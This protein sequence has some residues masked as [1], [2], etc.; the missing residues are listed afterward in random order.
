[1]F[2]KFPGRERSADWMDARLNGQPFASERWFVEASGR[3][4][5]TPY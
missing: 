2:G 3:I 4:V 5:K 1:V